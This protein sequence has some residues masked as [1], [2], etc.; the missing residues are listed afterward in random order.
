MYLNTEIPGNWIERILKILINPTYNVIFWLRILMFLNNS[1]FKKVIQKKLVIKYG[2][3]IGLNTEIGLGLKIPHPNG[4]I[5]GDGVK[6]GKNCTIFQQVTFGV[7]N[8]GDELNGKYPLI[9]DCCVF[10]AGSKIIGEII[11]D[12]YSTI[13]A[14][15]VVLHNTSGGGVYAGT[16][17]KKM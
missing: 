14:N 8:I 9:G 6:I 5:I 1:I 10:G 2:F 12:D 17:A 15:S 16:P 4:I 3:F 11:V 7:K 13:G